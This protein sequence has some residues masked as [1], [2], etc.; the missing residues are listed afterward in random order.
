MAFYEWTP[1]GRSIMADYHAGKAAD[2][3][4]A[5]EWVRDDE[6]IADSHLF[7]S[8]VSALYVNHSYRVEEAMTDE[9]W[10][11][12]LNLARRVGNRSGIETAYEEPSYIHFDPQPMCKVS[13]QPH[14][15]ATDPVT[16][17]VQSGEYAGQTVY[18]TVIG[19]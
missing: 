8:H 6:D 11:S 15:S 13:P 1:A 10:A 4:H 19:D 2:E 3:A 16:C 18:A 9:G 7:P 14:R 12:S 17:V 5:A